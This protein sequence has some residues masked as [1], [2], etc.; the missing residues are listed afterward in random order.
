MGMLDTVGSDVPVEIPQELLSLTQVIDI[1]SVQDEIV[2]MVQ[3]EPSTIKGLAERFDFGKATL[4]IVF[5]A[6][7][8]LDQ[9]RLVGLVQGEGDVM[10]RV[11]LNCP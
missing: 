11:I 6:C 10:V 9:E 7:L 8:F 1:T 3:K 4:A 2:A 5:L